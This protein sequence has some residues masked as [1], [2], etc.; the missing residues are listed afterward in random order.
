MYDKN[1]KDYL[2]DVDES[3]LSYTNT[4]LATPIPSRHE[5]VVRK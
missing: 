1:K 2:T 4:T 5:T 3:E